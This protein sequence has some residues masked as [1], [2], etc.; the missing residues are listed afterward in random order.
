M[1]GLNFE[2]MKKLAVALVRATPTAPVAYKYTD[3][4]GTEKNFTYQDLQETFRKELLPYAGT[5]ALFR[6]NQNFIFKLLEET[7]DEVLPIR[8]MQQYASFAEVKT[9]KQG[10]RPIFIQRITTASKRRAKQFIGKVGLNGL[11]EVFK[12]DGRSYEVTTNA[13]G[14]AAGIGFEEWLDGR[15]DFA[16]VLDVL[17]QGIDECIYQEIEAQLIGA[18]AAV[19]TTHKESVNGFNEAKFD[20]LLQVADQYG[21]KAD[22]Y[23]TFEFAATIIPS[24]GWISDEMRNQ[25][26]NN[27]Y[28]GN[29]KGHKVIV[30]NQGFEENAA[31]DI[32]AVKI[33]DPSYCWMIP[34][35][36]EKPVKIAIEGNTIVQEVANYDQSREVHMY[37][38]IGVR[39]VFAD[40]ICVYRNSDLTR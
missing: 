39:A 32:D 40:N 22:I 18:V 21:S 7:I 2:Q 11:Y 13:I 27:G 3:E 6:E 28:L 1:A 16:D 14:G 35:G 19:P 29:Y 38:K 30:L 37:K 36:A 33:I 4:N 31:G 9:F 15:V 23:C 17:Y 10:D 12:L 25:K 34:S 24:T 20:R 8:I 5:Y 26:W